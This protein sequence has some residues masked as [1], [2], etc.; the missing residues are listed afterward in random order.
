MHVLSGT[1]NWTT[2]DGSWR[3]L[4]AGDLY[5]GEDQK[6]SGGLGHTSACVGDVPLVLLLV[7]HADW[8]PHVN[9]PC[10]LK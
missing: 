9:A 5:L 10:W 1:G 6:A 2:V 7:Q 3:L 4:Q 8:V